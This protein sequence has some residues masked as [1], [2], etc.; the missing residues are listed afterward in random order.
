MNGNTKSYIFQ[1]EFHIEEGKSSVFTI[2]VNAYPEV[3]LDD[4]SWEKKTD[5][6][7]NIPRLNRT[8]SGTRIV[9]EGGSLTF[10][11]VSL[12]DAGVYIL[13]VKNEVGTSELAVKVA[14]LHPPR[15]CLFSKKL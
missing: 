11:S 15:Y 5:P 14:I 3:S 13:K 8:V 10:H 9:S 12:G 4:Y 6:V 2:G 7:I 1:E